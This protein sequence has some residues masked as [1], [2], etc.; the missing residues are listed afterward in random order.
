MKNEERTQ[1]MKKILVT[2]IAGLTAVTTIWG[3]SSIQ[4]AATLKTF[5]AITGLK[6]PLIQQY[7]KDTSK[8]IAMGHSNHLL[9][10]TF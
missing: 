9:S 2:L 3:E 10:H 8:D 4:A 6:H 1:F 7:R 5:Q